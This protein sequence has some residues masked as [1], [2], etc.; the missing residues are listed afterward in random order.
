MWGCCMW[1]NYTH[2]RA[3]TSSGGVACNTAASACEPGPQKGST[4]LVFLYF[5]LI[6]YAAVKIAVIGSKISKWQCCSQ[7]PFHLQEA[8]LLS[9]TLASANVR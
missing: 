5:F 8:P 7:Q 4:K 6:D 1:A 2:I 9:V 3:K